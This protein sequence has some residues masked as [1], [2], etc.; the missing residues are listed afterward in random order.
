MA[1]TTVTLNIRQLYRNDNQW[2]DNQWNILKHVFNTLRRLDQID[3]PPLLWVGEGHP[4][5]DL[6]EIAVHAR[7]ETVA[8]CLLTI[9][10]IVLLNNHLTD[11][12]HDFKHLCDV[13]VSD[14]VNMLAEFQRIYIVH[15]S[16]QQNTIIRKMGGSPDIHKNT[17][18]MLIYTLT[19]LEQLAHNIN[20]M[21]T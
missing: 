3:H 1:P 10:Q 6:C 11:Y 2:N 19:Q 8:A 18:E 17:N 12:L 9:L 4:M 13:P 7:S 21:H 14:V 5:L 16:I 15:Y 20:L